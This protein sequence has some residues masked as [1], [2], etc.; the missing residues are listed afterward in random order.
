MGH[1]DRNGCSNVLKINNMA[2][3][4]IC[5]NRMLITKKQH[6]RRYMIV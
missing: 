6:L 4:L 5:I 3:S 2:I 1:L